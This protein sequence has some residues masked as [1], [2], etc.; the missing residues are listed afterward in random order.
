MNRHAR[1]C[2]FAV[3]CALVLLS[4]CGD[5]DG[6][7]AGPD[8]AEPGGATTTSASP[9]T[10][11]LDGVDAPPDSVTDLSD[12][13]IALTQVAELTAPIDLTARRGSADLF[14]AERAGRVRIIGLDGSGQPTP[15]DAAV[16]VDIS[17]DTT[18]DGERGLL[19]LAFSPDGSQLYLSFTDD[20]GDTQIDEWQ[21]D[22]DSVDEA[23]RRTVYRAAQPFR[24]H[25][26][27]SIQFG[28]DGYLYLGLGDGGG[29]G[30]PLGAAQDP[31]SVLGSLIR[32][33]PTPH[34]DS[35][36]TVPP[37]NP[38]VDG[39]GAP[40]IWLTGV[41][42]PWRFAFDHVTGDLWIADVGQNAVEEI[43]VLSAGPDGE[44]AG[45]GANL[46][47]PIFE[48][49]EPFDGGPEPADYAP[50][51]HTYRHRPGCSIT[52]GYVSRGDALPALRGV[53]LYSDFCDPTI[54]AVLSRDGSEAEHR[55]LQVTVPGGLVV[56]FGE[57]PAGE[58]YVLS[59]G[60]GVFRIDPA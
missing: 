39:G 19:G 43:T 28:L 10:R 48:G 27:G 31:T 41:R 50:P 20:S 45:R 11:P 56:S 6:S 26:G 53:Y 32:I 49:D 4:A 21:I 60:G 24:N 59:L 51:V 38:F 57:G 54:H 25:N 16:L 2:R 46:G 13:A 14:V 17:S 29:S 52:G 9:V 30:D 8:G 15:G 18:T 35:P 36:F 5:D 3:V 23:S 1:L 34:G 40:E 55:S 44:G 58:L 12:A 37:D 42:N 7:P 33:D 47:W 22:G